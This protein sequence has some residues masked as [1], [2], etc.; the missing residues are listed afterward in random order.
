MTTKSNIFY[1]HWRKRDGA[2]YK[3]LAFLDHEE[4][5]KML[6]SFIKNKLLLIELEPQFHRFKLNVLFSIAYYQR[7]KRFC[8]KNKHIKGFVQDV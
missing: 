7:L 5:I 1:N 2:I 8:E 4:R 3:D 6:D